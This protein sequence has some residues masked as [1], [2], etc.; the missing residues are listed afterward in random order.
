MATHSTFVSDGIEF[1]IDLDD[2]SWHFRTAQ[3]AGAPAPAA[4][5]SMALMAE[6]SEERGAQNR[7][8]ERFEDTA[9]FM[10]GR[11]NSQGEATFTF[12]LPDN[13]TSWRVTASAISNDLYAGNT[14]QNVRVT[15]PMF[16]HYTLNSTFLAGDRP[17]VG[18]NVYGTSFSG[19]E[20][21]AFEVWREG[22]PDDIRTA[23]GA[24]FERVNIPLWEKASEG[25]GAIIIRATAGGYSDAI[26]H[27][28]RV[29]GSHRQVDMAVFYE[30]TP[31][32]VF[33]VNHGGLTNITFTDRGRG[34]FLTDL[35]T[36]RNA[37]WRSGARIEG[38]V[39]RREA[40][41]LIKAHFPEALLFGGVEDFDALEYQT[42]SGGI[43]ILP[44]AEADLQTTVML[45]PFI[46]DDVNL[47]AL[48]GY[49]RNVFDTSDTD[50]KMLALYGLAILGEP[51]L[52][53]LQSYAMLSDLS[54]RNAAYVAL[55]LV[56]LGETQAARGLYIARI[57][58]HVQ[59]VGAYYRIDLDM[60]RAETLD[61]TSASALIAAQLGMR[62]SVGLHG[63]AARYRF[64]ASNRNDALVMGIERLVFISHEI[65]NHTDTAASIT[66]TLFG[67]TTTRELGAGGQFNLRIPAQNMHEFNL[68]ST[69]G[70]VGAVSI[71][72]MPL[73]DMEMLE[74]DIVILR[75]FFRAG[76]H[77][78]TNT[79][80]QGDL[81]RV[82]ITINYSARDLSGSYAV[83]DFL[84]AGLVHVANSARFGEHDSAAGR[85]A[86]AKTEGARITF[87]DFNSRANRTRTYF[88][89]ARVINPGTFTA[90]G[91]L[92]Q[93]VGAREYM[94]VGEG[95]VLTIRP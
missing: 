85:W 29:I 81:V 73:E 92:V 68:I 72:R 93:S 6:A 33:E 32:T 4:A 5:P 16:V 43:A 3:T 27:T 50:N 9:S 38:L 21:V 89:Y 83:T 25:T 51:V 87:F 66:Y 45:L 86:W 34:Q 48:T 75:E 47:A 37:W 69:T 2:A 53:D 59:R 61:A 39:A 79:F 19:G 31:D 58:P 70:E 94:A 55:G 60:N 57:E 77:T 62:E 71:V 95:A 76:E 90:E 91:T 28:Y 14:V 64:D 30:V 54:V 78:P 49:L 44:Y 24:A 88:Y 80:A 13:I 12:Q 17:Y 40:T 63:Y 41:A 52:L 65:E 46:K 67:E 10:S 56:A 22:A 74:T 18:V 11:T 82:Q 8:R 1:Q 35:F 7:I 15:Q 23:T 20:Q 42:L 84:P 36:L 26:Q